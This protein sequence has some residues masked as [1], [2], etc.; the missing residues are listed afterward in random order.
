MAS[1]T[2]EE[3][4]NSIFNN[5]LSL[6]DVYCN[7]NNK[8]YQQSKCK[9][10]MRN[11][12]RTKFCDPWTIVWWN[13]GSITRVKCANND[14]YSKAG[15]LMAA[16]VK[17]YLFDDV[18]SQMSKFLHSV[19]KEQYMIKYPPTAQDMREAGIGTG[20][21]IIEQIESKLSYIYNN[22]RT[23]R[24]DITSYNYQCTMPLTD[25]DKIKI[26]R[27]FE[28]LGYKVNINK[29]PQDVVYIYDISINW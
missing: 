15:G 29:A 1:M 6:E 17:H 4:I 19:C 25:I 24:W 8:S 12:K 11:I 14:T 23:I 3:Y 18:A 7:I 10:M 2:I 9:K 5:S 13:D 27:H 21:S 26:I 16:M 28:N 22:R 20:D